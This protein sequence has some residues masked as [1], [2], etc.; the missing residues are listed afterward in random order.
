MIVVAN[1][2]PVTEGW[3]DRFLDRFRNRA[4]LIDD[5]PGFLR[6]MVLRPKRHP[7]QDPDAPEYHVVLTFWK[8]EEAFWAW[9]KSDSFRQAHADLPPEEMFAGTSILEMHEVM[10]DTNGSRD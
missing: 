9:T 2:I 5:A 3:E 10:M 1:R 7:H 6:N 4:G 8:D